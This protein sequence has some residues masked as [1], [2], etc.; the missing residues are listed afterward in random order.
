MTKL[1]LSSKSDQQNEPASPASTEAPPPPP[2]APDS[3]SRAAD[4]A[5]TATP[6]AISAPPPLPKSAPAP[7]PASAAAGRFPGR[8]LVKIIAFFIVTGI[9][10]GWYFMTH[11][12]A[13]LIGFLYGGNDDEAYYDDANAEGEPGAAAGEITYDQRD[14][15]PA[16]ELMGMVA[17]NRNSQA[18]AILNGSLVVPNQRIEGARL[19][20]IRSDGVVLEYERDQKFILVGEGTL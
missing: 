7:S 8:L 1:Q 16:I 9:L 17:A 6:P 5:P 11:D 15:W 2:P 3:D 18:S 10:L 13:S 12:G 14:D 19:I 20:E 4:Q